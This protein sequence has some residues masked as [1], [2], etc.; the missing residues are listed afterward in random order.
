[1]TGKNL[2]DC[3]GYKPYLRL[4]LD[5]DGARSGLRGEFARALRCQGSFVSQV[6]N[7]NQD[8]SL[9]QAYRANLHFEHDPAQ[10][11]FFMLLVQK[12]RAGDA[13][14]RGYFQSQIDAITS[15]RSKIKSRVSNTHAITETEQARYYS[16]WDFAAVH[17]CLAVPGMRTPSEL[18]R[19]LNLTAARVEFILDFLVSAG[20]AAKKGKEHRVGAIHMHLGSDS[21]FIQQHHSNWRLEALKRL[22]V[23]SPQNLHY[24]G[25]VSLSKKDFAQLRENLVQVVQDNL[26][27]VKPSPEEI[28]AVQMIDLIPIA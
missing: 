22:N 8:L 3:T 12:D 20:L 15:E 9:E 24:S 1:M 14:L 2:F 11:H 18:A 13:D 28:V 26:E 27:V 7:G 25:V 21:P 5:A 16:Q 4:R 17:M 19:A 10:A 6:L 23:T